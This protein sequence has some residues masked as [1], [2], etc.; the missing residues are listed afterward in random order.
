MREMRTVLLAGLIG[1]ATTLPAQAQTEGALPLVI[2]ATGSIHSPADRITLSF[3]VNGTGKTDAAAKADLATNLEKVRK[4]I[5]GAG[6]DPTQIHEND[7]SGG[8]AF[9]GN[10]VDPDDDGDQRPSPLGRS[11]ARWLRIEV[12]TQADYVRLRKAV[13]DQ[14][15]ALAP[16]PIFELKDDSA[17]HAAAV[18]DAVR[19]ARVEGSLYAAAI[20]YRVTRITKVENGLTANQQGFT[21]AVMRQMM[22]AQMGETHDV[23]TEAPVTITFDMVPL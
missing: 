7:E 19:K 11:A 10:A 6:F 20:G 15:L 23:L 2:S 9:I 21:A 22:D 14:G 3:V 18:A 5:A 12:N 16:N 8:P 4:A 13:L 1:C 17:A